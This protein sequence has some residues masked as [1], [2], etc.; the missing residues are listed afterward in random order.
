MK[1]TD[2]RLSPRSLFFLSQRHF[3]DKAKS[4][5]THHWV[6]LDKNRVKKLGV[7]FKKSNFVD[8]RGFGF[9]LF[10]KR[11]FNFR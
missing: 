9:F 3:K 6:R 8:F 11:N 5:R 1:A 2:L 4:L 10:L 7:F